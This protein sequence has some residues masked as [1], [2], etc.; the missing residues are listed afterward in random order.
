[1]GSRQAELEVVQKEVA[2]GQLD[3]L[4]FRM[5]IEAEGLQY[6]K[7]LCLKFMGVKGM[8]PSPLPVAFQW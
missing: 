5:L 4:E 1:M 3:T 8:V 7:D 6:V 2:C